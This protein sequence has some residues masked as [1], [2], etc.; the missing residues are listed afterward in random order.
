[1]KRLIL[2]LL[3]PL[4]ACSHERP[5]TDHQHDHEHTLIPHEHSLADHTHDSVEY[6]A[7][8]LIWDAPGVVVSDRQPIG[9]GRLTYDGAQQVWV[10]FSEPPIDLTVT[11][12]PD[13]DNRPTIPILKWYLERRTLKIWTYCTNKTANAGFGGIA[14]RLQWHS[15]GALLRYACG[16]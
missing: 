14:V 16:D 11:D 12:V 5:L 8:N 2:L 3:I 1:M 13:P 15:G 10:V 7:A 9:I 6:P 4:F